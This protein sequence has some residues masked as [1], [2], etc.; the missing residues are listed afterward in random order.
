MKN[1]TDLETVQMWE[2][3]TSL[4]TVSEFVVAYLSWAQHV[5]GTT[6]ISHLKVNRLLD[7]HA[8]IYWTLNYWPKNEKVQR[9]G[10]PSTAWCT[11]I[12]YLLNFHHYFSLSCLCYMLSHQLCRPHLHFYSVDLCLTDIFERMLYKPTPPAS[13]LVA[14][15]VK[16]AFQHLDLKLGILTWK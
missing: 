15:Y 1:T 3:K 7:A 6:Y 14:Q 10:H 11:V 9:N 16:P 4:S 13:F 12:N 8:A 2:R 5:R